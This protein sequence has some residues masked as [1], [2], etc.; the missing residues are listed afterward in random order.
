MRRLKQFFHKLSIR[1][2]MLTI[3]CLVGMLPVLVLGISLGINSY[4]TVLKYREK[5][6]TNTLQQAC[7]IVDYQMYTCQ[8]MMN[9][10][11]YNQDV[12]NF[13]ECD[14]TKK[15]QR[16][17]LYQEVSNT[18]GALKYQNLI[19][20]SVTIY[21][22]GIRQSFGNE[23]HPLK[24]LY[25]ESWYRDGIRDKE[26]VFD[27]NTLDLISIYKIPS[28]SG[29]ESYVAV[30]TDI[31]TLFESLNQLA[32]EQYGVHVQT[33]NDE[34][35][36][37]SGKK[38]T[39]KNGIYVSF[40]ENKK[41]YLWVQQDLNQMDATVTYFQKKS[42]ISPF[43]GRAFLMIAVQVSACLICIILLGRRFAKYLSR[44]LEEL[45]EEIQSMD[46]MNIQATVHSNREDEMGILINSYNHMMRRIQELIREN[47]ETQIAQKEFEMKALQAQI[48][49][50][51][52][53]N[54]LSMINWKAI[55]AGE[56][57]ISQV[58]LALS[59]FYRTTLNKG[60][61]WI[62]LRLALQNIQA[63]VQLQLWMHD[64]DFNAHYD[65]DEKLLDYELPSL[66]FQPFVEN[67][68]EHGLDIKEDPQTDLIYVSI[69]DNGVGMDTDT[70]AHVLEYHATGY[71]V[72]NVNDRMK[73]SFGEAYAIQIKSEQGKGTEV[74][75]HFPKVQ[76]GESNE[77]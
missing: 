55:E 4:R 50:H 7:G 32:V 27:E 10:F 57:E 13:L 72:K 59:A 41:D 20:E 74:L 71:G 36:N 77:S 44:P 9:Y 60:R 16:Y 5:D 11:V 62:S 58:T 12:I 52:L 64:N 21:S 53:Y 33:Q 49:P 47:Y 61:T 35:W 25:K 63:Y 69:R 76:K 46:E 38:C 56:E 54:S 18:I 29:I 48:N 23:T 65:V 26:W 22:E 3:L 43:S 37:F 66:I 40:R 14:P 39:D 19:M 51:F 6:M 70:L 45:T 73:L 31:P 17:E 30:R 8:Q 75:L 15:T 67:A 68:L 1:K 28:Y 42:N 34:I 24:D 2:K